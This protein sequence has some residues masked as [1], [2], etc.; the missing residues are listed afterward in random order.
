MFRI[1]QQAHQKIISSSGSEE[2][3]VTLFKEQNSLFKAWKTCLDAILLLSHPTKEQIKKKLSNFSSVFEVDL[4]ELLEHI[5]QL[6]NIQDDFILLLKRYIWY[7]DNNLSEA[8]S[9]FSENE[10]YEHEAMYAWLESQG[11]LSHYLQFERQKYEVMTIEIKNLIEKAKEEIKDWLENHRDELYASLLDGNLPPACFLIFSKLRDAVD[12]IFGFSLE[13]PN[14]ARWIANLN[15]Y[16]KNHRWI[17]YEGFLYSA[18]YFIGSGFF[19]LNLAKKY[20]TRLYYYATVDTDEA[21]FSMPAESSHKIKMKKY[22]DRIV[23]HVWGN[24]N[25]GKQWW[26][27]YSESYGPMRCATINIT[28][29]RT[30]IIRSETG[31]TCVL[32]ISPELF[33]GRNAFKALNEHKAHFKGKKLTIDLIQQDADQKLNPD[34][35]QYHDMTEKFTLFLNTEIQPD[36]YLLSIHSIKPV[37]SIP[38]EIKQ[39]SDLTFDVCITQHKLN[40]PDIIVA[41]IGLQS[42]DYFSKKISEREELPEEGLKLQITRQQVDPVNLQKKMLDQTIVDVNK[43]KRDIELTTISSEAS[44]KIELSIEQKRSL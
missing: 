12:E 37:A 9:T 41:N 29:C 7:V 15:K 30:F 21:F 38:A 4:N 26:D 11:F 3:S 34:F 31:E 28:G 33:T 20:A 16:P 6:E 32:H 18:A 25:M 14:L 2:R 13:S 23:R 24:Q 10:F 17:S 36:S 39:V 19:P 22:E 40:P 35:E 44:K 42:I 5:E 43:N 1:L 27:G 8:Y